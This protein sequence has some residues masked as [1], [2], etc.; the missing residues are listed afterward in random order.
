VSSTQPVKS[1]APVPAFLRVAN[2]H[3]FGLELPWLPSFRG[4]DGD[5]ALQ[6]GEAFGRQVAM[7]RAL[8]EI[9][10]RRPGALQ[11]RIVV[12]EQAQHGRSSRIL[13]VFLLGAA[14][15][16][17]DAADLRSRL[18]ATLPPEFVVE[19]VAP[20]LLARLLDVDDEVPWSVDQLAEIRR[21]IESSDP[22]SDAGGTR[23]MAPVLLRWVWNRVNLVASLGALH[24]LPPG[25]QLIVHLE[26]RAV[27]VDALGWLRE[28]ISHLRTAYEDEVGSNPLH[29]A[30]VNGYRS[31]LRDL[32]RACL[33]L[34]VLLVSPGSV[35]PAGTPEVVG[36][37]LTRSWE[38]GAPVG[39]FDIVRP[40][41]AP[42]LESALALIQLMQSN[43][44]RPPDI[45]ELAELLHLFDPHEASAAFRLPLPG[46]EGLPGL[47][48]E[49]ASSL[50]RG[51]ASALTPDRASIVLGEGPSADTVTLAHG[52]INRH[53]LVAGLP[54][55]G[56]TTT[57]QSILR[58]L[59]AATDGRRQVPFLV[60][61]PAKTD[62]R[63]L[64]EELGSDCHLVE[65]GSEHVAFNPLGRPEGVPR[66]VFATRISAAFDA[67]YD[68]STSFPAAG[69]VLTR[70][71]HRVLS[72]PAPT[73]PRLYATVRDLV[74]HSD[75]S[76]R[77]KGEIEAAL[78]NR[79]ELLTDGS[80][81][82]AL[83]GDADSA[84]DW[85][86][87]VSRPTIVLA[88]EFAGPRERALLMSLVLA[89]LVSY[90]EYH[91]SAGGLDHVTVVEEAHRILSAG[92][93]SGYVNDG[94]QVFVDA[95][96]E[97]RGAGEGFVVVEQ[98]PSRL[99]PEVRKLVGTVIAHRTVDAE[100]R[101]VLAASLTLPE[102]EQDLAR[103]R[104]GSAIVLAAD[105]IT[106]TVVAVDR[107]T[108]KPATTAPLVTRSL[109]T[110][111]RSLRLW[112]EDCP[113]VCTGYRGAAR[114]Q[115]ARRSAP[116]VP[117]LDARRMAAQGLTLAEGYCARAFAD[118]QESPDAQS[119]RVRRRALVDAYRRHVKTAT[120]GTTA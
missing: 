27:S 100:E 46:P 85:A 25:A 44:V 114:V 87:V 8:A 83:M 112:C 74:R 59:W 58:Q 95:M 109:A 43:S 32:P 57:V 93:T 72:E 67:A 82:S 24:R 45:P 22:E 98:A 15:H 61:D 111:A 76:E 5:A 118:A 103:L 119:W 19:P 99:I 41:T 54:G 34:R 10:R 9:G 75:Y 102:S 16:A 88:R 21:A 13:R 113:V 104:P 1:A 53:V 110:D 92:A 65:L 69:T 52:E 30:V 26:P 29:V 62:Y 78:V 68:L 63:S 116:D 4:R 80:L 56:K 11:L 17:D 6:Y 73:L 91:P 39:T 20:E 120:T 90:R 2:R 33:H 40:A 36:A 60:L 70:A 38:S 101:A 77:T 106:P 81:G 89:G 28:E 84:V 37:D 79:L 7:L 50:P 107:G 66:A 71:V 18:Q 14:N 55:Y 49:P 86:T 108:P 35:L 31:W 117:W 47:R 64:A 96:A 105:M 23:P 97:L 48:S 3:V 51:L 12:D 42:E 94:A 115:E